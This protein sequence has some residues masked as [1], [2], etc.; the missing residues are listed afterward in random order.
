MEKTQTTSLMGRLGEGTRGDPRNGSGL[1]LE[2]GTQVPAKLGK[3]EVSHCIALWARLYRI[4][5]P[6]LDARN[7]KTRGDYRREVPVQSTFDW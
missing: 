4:G 3:D 2:K 6:R 1:T 5:G 7:G